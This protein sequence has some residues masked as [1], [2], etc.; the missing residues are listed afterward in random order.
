MFN[1]ILKRILQGIPVIF[2]VI[3]ISFMLIY[4]APGDPVLAMVGD[5]YDE[6]TL[7]E[8]RQELHLDK[9][10]INQYIMFIGRI[11]TGD[12]GKSYISDRYV[13]DDLL[14]KTPYTLQLAITAMVFAI[15]GGIF[16]GISSA[17][18]H[19]SFWDKFAVIFSIGG[20]SAPVFW[21]ALLLILFFGV[22]LQIL[23]PSGY[24]GWQYIILPGIA[25]GMRSLA[26]FSRITRTNFLEIM[27]EDYMTTAKAKGL[28][29]Y[30]VIFKHGLKNLLIPLITII[31]LDFGS[32]LT[33]AVLTESIF[34]WPGLGRM[35][36][37]A[38]MKRDFPVIQGTVLFMVL[39]F[40]IINILVDVLYGIANPQIRE[41]LLNE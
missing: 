13:L 20:I 17:L 16:F 41:T 27:H 28:P 35:M 33:G 26:L 3:T 36:L 12:F 39:I 11:C 25:L 22:E 15:I 1:Y 37:D 4:V 8:L 14:E 31:G 30:I 40:V 34:G 23:P 38:I 18:H 2:G 24:G 10:M 29:D 7:V 6:D 32:Y 21:V 19:N 5:Y 9:P